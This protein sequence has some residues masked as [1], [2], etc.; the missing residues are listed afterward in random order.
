[1]AAAAAG[2]PPP[3]PEDVGKE[4][5]AALLDEIARGGCVDSLV[6]PLALTLMAL[7]PQNVSRL[8]LG[9]LSPA[10]IA[11]LRLLRDFLGCTFKL[12]PQSAQAAAA[13]AAAAGSSSSSSSSSSISSGGGGRQQRLRG[14]RRRRRRRQ[15]EHYYS[16]LPGRGVQKQR[17]ARDVVGA[18]IIK[19]Y[20]T[21]LIGVR[22]RLPSRRGSL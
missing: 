2:A 11:T 22:A 9:K 14:R 12:T 19:L 5:A 18:A 6:Q 20:S 1:M 16:V 7:C 17:K 15:R 4:A 8:R 3:P 13:E 10:A 21:T